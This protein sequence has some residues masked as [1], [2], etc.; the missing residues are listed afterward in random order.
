[1]LYTI[2]LDEVQVQTLESILSQAKPNIV[3]GPTVKPKKLTKTE[4]GLI[5]LREYRD[6][7]AQKKR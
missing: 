2:V 3:L 5:K 4:L 6:R 1:M 7:K